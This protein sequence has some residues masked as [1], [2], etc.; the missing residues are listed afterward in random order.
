MLYTLCMNLA[1]LT[2][3]KALLDQHRPLPEALVRNLDAWFR[4]ELTYSSNAIEGNTLSR[5]ETALVLEKGLTVGGKSLVEH[6]EAVN[7]ARGHRL[8]SRTG[9]AQPA[10]SGRTGYFGSPL[11]GTQGHRRQQRGALPERGGANCRF[12]GGAAQIH[13]RCRTSWK[14]FQR[15][16]A[17]R[18]MFHTVELAAEAHYRLVSIHPFVDGNGRTARLLMNLMLLMTGYPGDHPS[19]GIGWPI[20]GRWRRHSLA[21]RRMPT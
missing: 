15:G 5:R 13:A 21:A 17:R 4:V 1:D 7:H 10:G 11:P 18:A 20:S 19:P 8:D 9:R 16:C 14:P 6:L 3:K 12:S 2:A